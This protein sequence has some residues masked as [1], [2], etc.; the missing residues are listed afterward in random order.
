MTIVAMT[1]AHINE[2]M[3]YEQDMFGPE[4]W[5]ASAY[6]EE[7]AD[8]FQRYYVAA[9]GEDKKLLG[10]AGL[11]VVADEAEILTIGVIPA[12]RRHGVGTELL[13][14]LIDEARRRAAGVVFLDV[15]LAN[16]DAQRIYTREG[17][18]VVGRRRG[19]YDNGRTDSLTMSLVLGP[20]AQ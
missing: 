15:R 20:V 1:R 4:S 5:S 12:A 9:V 6:R 8:R 19:Y 14:E 17:F 7:L 13:G 11:R 2:I 16:E 18:T 3:R 10:W